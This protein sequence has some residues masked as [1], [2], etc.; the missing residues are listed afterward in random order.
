M[1]APKD[2]KLRADDTSVKMGNV[3][4]TR[5]IACM[6]AHDIKCEKSNRNQ[7]RLEHWDFKIKGEYRIEVK[8]RKK[9]S[10]GATNPCDDIVYVE[11]RGIT[12]KAGWL[13]GKADFIAFERPEGFMVIKRTDLVTLA[14]VSVQDVWSDRPALYK[15]Y[16][17]YDRPDECVTVLPIGDVLSLPNKMFRCE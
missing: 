6:K 3:A 14:E 17:R 4:E 1:T 13:Y 10:R 7:D 16:K 11:F 8:S 12:G 9:W 15:K 5:F 2:K